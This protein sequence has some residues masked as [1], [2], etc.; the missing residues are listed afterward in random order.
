MTVRPDLGIHQFGQFVLIHI[1][2]Q[3]GASGDLRG[4]VDDPE[5]SL[6]DVRRE[7][8]RTIQGRRFL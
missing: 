4:T 5:R 1:D 7:E 8:L 3:S 6:Q 2:T